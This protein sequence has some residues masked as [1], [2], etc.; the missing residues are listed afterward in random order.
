MQD[1][2]EYEVLVQNALRHVVRDVLSDV[3]KAGSLPGEHHF[4]ITFNTQAAGVQIS[5]RLKQRFPESMTIVLQHR[6]W[7]MK[8][9]AEYFSVR[10]SFGG[11]P[12]KLTVPFAAMQSFYDPAAA[13]EV[14]FSSSGENKADIA[15]EN[16]PIDGED[17]IAFPP[18]G[19]GQ[20]Q[21]GFKP[22]TD[23]LNET[24]DDKSPYN[25][26]V[27][28]AFA[29]ALEKQQAHLKPEGAGGSADKPSPA[30]EKKVDDKGQQSASIVSL[31]AFRKK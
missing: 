31:D 19:R 22:A 9:Y 15:Q 8:V 14:A 4:Y 11:V 3:A 27:P 6:F 26:P 28:P 13:F 25:V 24:E 16:M 17:I 20:G 23:I 29:K 21:A 1:R 2:I 5:P 30:D 10:L 12:E 7:D 18:K